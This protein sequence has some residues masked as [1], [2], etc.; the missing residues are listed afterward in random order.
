MRR[1]NIL[2]NQEGQTAI[3]YMLLFGTVVAIVLIGFKT[4]VPR[5]REAANVYFDRAA[6]GIMGEPSPCG[7]GTCTAGESVA[8]CPTDC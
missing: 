7:D 4:Y 8:N 6:V 2:N 1:K 5:M 3:E